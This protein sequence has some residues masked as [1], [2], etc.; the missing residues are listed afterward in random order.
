MK[1]IEENM[2]NKKIRNN[3]NFTVEKM[4][5]TEIRFRLKI[6]ENTIYSITKSG[7]KLAWQK[8]H[9][10]KNCKEI[11]YVQKGKMKIITKEKD[12]VFCR[13][14]NKGDKIVVNEDVS[15]NVFLYED[16]QICV[17]KYGNVSNN[18]W[19]SDN[20]LDSICKSIFN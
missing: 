11:Y 13:I 6:D 19:Y 2:K 9:Y 12:F 4:P 18:N 10:H 14:L 1:I 20:Q 8:S 15:H 3:L 16:T 5:N 17:L 7:E